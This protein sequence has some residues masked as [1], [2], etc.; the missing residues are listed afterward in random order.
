MDC[1]FVRTV[2]LRVIAAALAVVCGVDS[3]SAGSF[4]IAPCVEINARMTMGLLARRVFD[5]HLEYSP[6]SGLRL[7]RDI[8]SGSVPSGRF[9]LRMDYSPSG[10]HLPDD[11]IP[12]THFSDGFQYAV[13][14]FSA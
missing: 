8:R 7:V 12:L 1:N 13:S 5:R 2:A 3:A 4:R 14:V 6:D 10:L 9:T 11:A